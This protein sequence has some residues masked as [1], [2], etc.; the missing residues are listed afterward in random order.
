LVVSTRLVGDKN[1]AIFFFS[2]PKLWFGRWGR[3]RVSFVRGVETRRVK[4]EEEQLCGK[5]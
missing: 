2:S 4:P 3:R 1:A 5:Q